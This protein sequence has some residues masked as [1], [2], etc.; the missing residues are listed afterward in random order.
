M[1][2]PRL[3][4]RLGLCTVLWTAL[5][6]GQVVATPVDVVLA[7]DHS[8]SMKRTDPNRDSVRGV[9]LFA[10]LLGKDDRLAFLSF[11]ERGERLLPLTSLA[12][13]GARERLFQRAQAVPMNGQ[14]TDFGAA[15]PL[16]YADFTQQ[17]SHSNAQRLLVIFSDGQLDLGSET[18]NRAAQAA[19]LA[20]LP[21]FRDAG[22]RIYGVAFSPEAD[23]AFLRQLADATGGQAIRA[24][25]VAD[26]YS[27][28][29][30]LF[31]D[32]DQPLAVPV[33][34]GRVAVDAEVKELKLLVGRDSEQEQIRLVDPSGTEFGEQNRPPGLEWRHH[35]P[36]DRITVTQPA[37]GSWQVLG[38]QGEKKAYLD[39]DLDVSVALPPQF[40]AGEP[41]TLGV[42]LRYRDQPLNDP[43]LLAGVSVAVTAPPDPLALRLQA[44][45]EHPQDFQGEL[46][47][48][49][50]GDYRLTVLAESPVFQ[51]RRELS[52]TVL[53]AIPAPPAPASAAVTT[54]PPKPPPVPESSP[55]PRSLSSVLGWV[56]AVN[57][58]L[59]LG[60]GLW[61]WRYRAGQKQ[62]RTLAL[63]LAENAPPRRSGP[64]P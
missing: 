18:A 31:E 11:A 60:G 34:E 2:S 42:Q 26:I 7:L 47:F 16:A 3:F 49:A 50:A 64:K 9:E 19:I 17:A 33:R 40:R 39:S 10:D 35:G 24:E 59:V 41:A 4:A 32:T 55:S 57:L 43:R 13:P 30:R 54:S 63:R 48:A 14:L 36:F 46:R 5:W 25:R 45:A 52:V 21:A 1:N 29:V 15:L 51:R 53:P 27:A 6:A 23:L 37:V 8:G 38:T 20:Q 61:F 28:F 12:L 44:Q 58:I 22:I 56:M 62:D